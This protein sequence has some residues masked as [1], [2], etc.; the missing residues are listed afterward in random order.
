MSKSVLENLIEVIIIF[1]ITTG[2]MLALGWAADKEKELGI[3]GQSSASI[4]EK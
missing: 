2:F 1:T 4:G 3:H